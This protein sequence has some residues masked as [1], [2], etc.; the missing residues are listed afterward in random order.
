MKREHWFALAATFAFAF[1]WGMSGLQLLPRTP[2]IDRTS[3]YFRNFGQV[4]LQ[5]WQFFSPPPQANIRLYFTFFEKGQPDTAPPPLRIELFQD[6]HQR[7]FR[8]FNQGDQ[9]LEHVLNGAYHD[10]QNII[11][12]RQ[13]AAKAA[14][15]KSAAKAILSRTP[16]AGNPADPEL[17]TPDTDPKLG[18]AAGQKSP[19]L[20]YLPNVALMKNRGVRVYLAYAGLLAKENGLD[21]SRYEAAFTGTQLLMPKFSAS[22]QPSGKK[23]VEIVLF[24]SARFPLGTPEPP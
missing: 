11:R 1:F 17:S 23:E 3:L 18:A 19:P 22:P 15:S 14:A 2:V 6:V 4:F 24:Q 12:A 20:S 21:P 5:G 8:F 16:R 13:N 10:I 7:Q 9:I